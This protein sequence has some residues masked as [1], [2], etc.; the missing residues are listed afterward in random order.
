MLG[1]CLVLSL[2]FAQDA[3]AQPPPTDPGSLVDATIDSQVGVLLDEIPA[4]MRDRVVASLLAKPASYWKARAARQIKHTTYRLVFRPFFYNLNNQ[5]VKQELPLPQEPLWNITLTG[6]AH[7]TTVTGHDLVVVPYHMQTTI[8]STPESPEVSEQK[9]AKIGGFWDEPFDLPID[10]ELLYQR[11]GYACMDEADFPFDTV[12]SE[13]TDTYYDSTCP[14]EKVLTA[15][16]GCHQTAL[17]T[18]SC[19]DAL[20]H[21]VGRVTTSVHYTRIAWNQ[22]KADAVRYYPPTNDTVDMQVF[23]E[24]FT[25]HQVDWKYFAPNS[26]EEQEHC[27]GAPGWRRVLQ[28]NSSDQNRGTKTL[29]IG[30]VDYY[31]TGTTT[32]NDLY[33]IF[34][35]HQCHQHY[36]FTHYGQFKY[37]VPGANVTNKQGFCLQSTDRAAN[38]EQSPLYEPYAGCDFQGVAAGWVD[39]YKIGLPCQWVDVTDVD[40][41][42]KDVTGPLS[43]TSNPDGFLCEGT[44]V[45]DA[46]G[47]PVFEPT[48]FR[49]AAGEVVYRPKCVYAPGALDNNTEAYP[50]TLTK[51]SDTYVGNQCTRGQI[52]PHRNCGMSLNKDNLTCTPG[53]TT[54]MRCTVAHTAKPQVARVC[55]RIQS[56][57]TSY[58]CTDRA[59]LASAPVDSTLDFNF[60]C[61]AARDAS[62]PGGHVA[63]YGGA[64]FPDADA[65]GGMTCT[66]VP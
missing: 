49:T 18:E 24:D 7:R 15:H 21:H 45:L 9:L 11:T 35:F 31:L 61:P 42:K 59:A 12:D 22:A 52:G 47:N 65:A 56:R 50:V 20:D 6:A 66:I 2:A 14:V 29:N 23:L 26:C 3:P 46:N 40:T 51:P 27:I 17:P 63:V 41:S 37:D 44:P 60:K 58:N 25:E 19:V 33:H 62:E 39:Q 1:T 4:S 64:V 5:E 43:F 16:D 48:E 10:P 8:L 32:L 13:Q 36:H 54:H 53:A 28:F 34:E 38:H 30:S 55:E 57:N